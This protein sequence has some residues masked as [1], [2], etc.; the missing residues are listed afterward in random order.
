MENFIFYE[1]KEFIDTGSLTKTLNPITLFTC[2]TLNEGARYKL[3]TYTASQNNKKYSII[4]INLITE[5]CLH[6]SSSKIVLK[7]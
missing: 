7:K 6:N 2:L 5:F 4:S 3:Q 1:I